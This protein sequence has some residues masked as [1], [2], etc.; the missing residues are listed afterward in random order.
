VFS[1]LARLLDEF[2]PRNAASTSHRLLMEFGKLLGAKVPL[3]TSSTSST[4]TTLCSSS[5]L[6]AGSLGHSNPSSQ[7]FRFYDL[8]SAKSRGSTLHGSNSTAGAGSSKKLMPGMPGSHMEAVVACLSA[9]MGSVTTKIQKPESGELPLLKQLPLG[10][11]SPCVN[12]HY[13]AVRSHVM[14][15]AVHERPQQVAPAHEGPQQGAPAAD[16]KSLRSVR[17]P[18]EPHSHQLQSHLCYG[19]TTALLQPVSRPM[20]LLS[21]SCE[22]AD[23]VP[24]S[25]G[26]G[27]NNPDSHPAASA[28]SSTIKAPPSGNT[29]AGKLVPG[30]SVYTSTQ[31]RQRALPGAATSASVCGPQALKMPQKLIGLPASYAL[32]LCHALM[33]MLL[34]PE[35]TLKPEGPIGEGVKESNTSTEA[36][37]ATSGAGHLRGSVM[38]KAAQ[39]F[40]VCLDA[41]GKLS[42][43]NLERC[44]LEMANKLD[45]RTSE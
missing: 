45:K 18:S 28:A 31:S 23:S 12:L 40:L 21:D 22:T 6:A 4:T 25:S 11:G 2:G 24:C 41:I 5:G 33:A 16:S 38:F 44:G 42:E 13:D 29:S 17:V 32:Q 1:N 10:K 3:S 15:L 20:P 34:A 27:A 19:F 30:G 8:C 37:P 14:Q 7:L 35:P 9:A 39:R 26:S 43:L 36:G